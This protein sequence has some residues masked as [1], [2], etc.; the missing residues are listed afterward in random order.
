V[1]SGAPGSAVDAAHGGQPAPWRLL[2]VEELLLG[3]E[4]PLVRRATMIQ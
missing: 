3:A 2:H 4:P 1:S